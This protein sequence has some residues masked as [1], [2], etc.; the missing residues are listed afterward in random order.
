MR[1]ERRGTSAFVWNV[2][3]PCQQCSSSAGQK[4]GHGSLLMFVASVRWFGR[5]ACRTQPPGAHMFLFFA[6]CGWQEP[7][8]V[9]LH[10]QGGA[11]RVEVQ[12]SR[13]IEG[14]GS[15]GTK[16]NVLLVWGQLSQKRLELG[17]LAL[18][19]YLFQKGQQG[20]HTTICPRCCRL[21]LQTLSA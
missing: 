12:I 16:P 15:I 13:W 21:Y 2:F 10:G 5:L 7:L 9:T 6:P 1:L 17:R 14:S 18:R 20:F 8:L 19:I 4:S 11:E 3:L